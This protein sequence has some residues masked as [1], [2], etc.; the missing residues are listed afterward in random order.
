MQT[1]NSIEYLAIDVANKYGMDKS[2]WNQRLSWFYLNKENLDF[3]V[4][5]AKEPMQYK[6]A[7]DAYRDAVAGNPIGHLISLDAVASGIQILSA[8]LQDVNGMYLCNLTSKDRKDP[9]T[10]IYTNIAPV[11]GNHITREQCKKAIMT[12]CYG[13]DKQP[14]EIFGLSYLNT[15]HE[16]MNKSLPN[17]WAFN[18]AMKDAWNPEALEYS[19]VMPDN[20][21][22]KDKVIRSIKEDFKFFDKEYSFIRKE[23]GNKPLGRSLGANITHSIDALLMREV[24]ARCMFSQTVDNI[25]L[26]I[27]KKDTSNDINMVRI[28]WGHYKRTGFLSVRILDYLGA[29]GMSF[30]DPKVIKDLIHTMPKRP[31][32]VLG[33]HD[34]FMV[35]PN[36]GNEIR[37]QYNRVLYDIAKSILLE[38][39][40]LE[41]GI[42]VTIEK[43]M[44][45]LDQILEADYA[46]C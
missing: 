26:G 12:S 28:L 25:S 14:K 35:H 31:F 19:W 2:N 7:V 34:N 32:K 46:I 13:S 17:V 36:Y 33:I 37:R 22:V 44:V 27:L 1:F 10:E 30:V 5:E 15:F 8:C 9:Y 43:D 3:L 21:H 20:F 23:Y 6:A 42:Q 39:I 4:Q 40:L 11:V 41:L 29:K 16:E 45:L 38:S 24:Q 18:Q